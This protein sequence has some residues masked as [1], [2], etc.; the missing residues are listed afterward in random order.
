MR[1]GGTGGRLTPRA[2][3]LQQPGSFVLSPFTELFDVS[4]FLAVPG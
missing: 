1:R 2:P 4:L 3:G